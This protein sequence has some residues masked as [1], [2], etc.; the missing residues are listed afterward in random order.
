MKLPT[1]NEAKPDT[2]RTIAR[3]QRTFHCDG[4]MYYHDSLRQSNPIREGK[5]KKKYKINKGKEQFMI[6]IGMRFIYL[7]K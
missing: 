3:L 7:Y 5:Q 4:T 6:S 1:V 2:E